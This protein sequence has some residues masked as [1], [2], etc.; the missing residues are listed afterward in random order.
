MHY[1]FWYPAEMFHNRFNN[2]I[3]G[4]IHMERNKEN[5]ISQLLGDRFIPT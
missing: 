2:K 3:L 1:L 4:I 5:A